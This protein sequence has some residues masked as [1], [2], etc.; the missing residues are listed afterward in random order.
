[1]KAIV[2]TAAARRALRGHANRAELILAKI[3][4]Y[5]AAPETQANNV[6]KLRGCL[7][8][9]LRV[10]DFRV[11]FSETKDTITIHDIG[12]RGGIYD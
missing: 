1:M 5:A 12:P 2:Y 7:D 8:Y 4:Q 10:G 9:R 6:K 3:E 11:V